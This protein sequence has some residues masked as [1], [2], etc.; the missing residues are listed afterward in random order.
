[1]LSFK[2]S[3]APAHTNKKNNI[4]MSWNSEFLIII[5]QK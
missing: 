3:I 2:V 5:E 1:M 4:G